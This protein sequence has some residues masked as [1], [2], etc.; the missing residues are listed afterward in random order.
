MPRFVAFLRGVSPGNARMPELQRCFESAGFTNVRTVLSSGNV[1]FDARSTA[2]STLERRAE[3]AMA[4]QL[5]RGFYTIV[6]PLGQL[7]TLL[8]SN[9]YASYAVL[10]D[11]KRVI[12]FLRENRAPKRPLPLA[13][14]GATVL[15]LIGREAFTAY[16]PTNKGPVFMKLIESAFGTDVTTRTW[17]T[18]VRCAAG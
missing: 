13:A 16:R 3:A 6:R 15:C 11:A 14:D 17:D 2:E 18:V 4:Q 5:G 10:G 12:T 1:V 7:H 9:P 8:A